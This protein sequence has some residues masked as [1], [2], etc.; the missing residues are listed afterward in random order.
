MHRRRCLVNGPK[1]SVFW[2]NYFLPPALSFAALIGFILILSLNILRRRRAER[3]LQRHRDHL[4]RQV[5]ARTRELSE[6]N[7][8][9]MGSEE[10]F[11][12][13]SDAAF[14]GI[15]LSQKGIVVEVNNTCCETLGYQSIFRMICS[16]YSP[17]LFFSV[18]SR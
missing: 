4:E 11:R 18:I 15:V 6:S 14:E 1:S 7:K 5:K 2:W 9:L 13:L 17:A 10:R 12:C 3:E 16:P 8:A